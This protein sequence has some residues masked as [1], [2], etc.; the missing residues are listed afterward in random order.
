MDLLLALFEA[1]VGVNSIANAHFL[2]GGTNAPEQVFP[3]LTIWNG[4]PTVTAAICAGT[5]PRLVSITF[6]GL[7]IPVATTLP[8]FNAVGPALSWVCADGTGVAVA[9]GVAVGVATVVGVAGTV[10]GVAVCGGVPVGA[11]VAGVPVGVAVGT[12]VGVGVVTIVGV[13]V[14][15]VVGVAV[16]GGVPVGVGVA[17]VPV[18]VAVGAIV[19]L[20]VVTI[21]GVTVGT[22]AGVGVGGGV[23]VGVGLAGVPVGVAVGMDVGVAVAVCVGAPLPLNATVSPPT[24]AQL[25]Q[26]MVTESLYDCAFIGANTIVSV[27]GVV[28]TVKDLD[29]IKENGGFGATIVPDA[30]P[31]PSLEMENAMAVLV[32]TGTDPKGKL[33]G[34]T[35]T[36][37]VGVAVG[38]E[39]AVDVGVPV[40]VAVAVCVGAP[41]PLNATVF[42]PTTAQLVQLMVTESLY[43][44]ALIG[45]K[46]IVSVAGVVFTLKDLEPIKENGGLGALIVPDALPEPWL[47]ME[48]AI[49]VLVPTGFEPK[50]KLWGPMEITGVGD[51]VGVGVPISVAVGVAVGVAVAVGVGVAVDP[52][53]SAPTSHASPMLGRG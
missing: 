11:G 49:A 17:G 9:T 7:L 35:M 28:L 26:L 21:V 27:A 10:V 5:V 2:F 15:M 34:P 40:G 47:E 43:D 38:V 48:N 45:E 20:G 1:M 16:G 6:R 4:I 51:G 19:G 24:T 12:G 52:N 46:T 33:W 14:G 13:A 22:V 44:C 50:V 25:V 37:G 23:P 36:T 42:P 32:P 3:V 29:P 41:L 31:D 18:G 53:S 39:E 8:K 30:V